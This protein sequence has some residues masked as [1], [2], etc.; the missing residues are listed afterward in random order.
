MSG[1]LI[2]FSVKYTVNTSLKRARFKGNSHKPD[3]GAGEQIIHYKKKTLIT[4]YSERNMTPVKNEQSLQNELLLE[5]LLFSHCSCRLLSHH[6]L[7]CASV[8]ADRIA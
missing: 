7:A 3:G 2:T 6:L 8:V 5:G 4:T 1:G